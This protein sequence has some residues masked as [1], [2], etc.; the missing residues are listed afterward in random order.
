[1]SLNY[2]Q[3]SLPGEVLFTSCYCLHPT[4]ECSTQ[5]AYLAEHLDR[6]RHLL[7]ADLLVLLLLGGGLEPLPGQGA[8]V[9]VH[10][11]VAQAL[12]VVPPALFDPEVGVDGGVPSRAGQVL[13]FPEHIYVLGYTHT[14]RGFVSGVMG[15]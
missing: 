15:G 9:E 2:N 12:H 7:L 11:H 5:Y 8:P 10:Q 1:M 13:V 4:H 6:G 14:G 3:E